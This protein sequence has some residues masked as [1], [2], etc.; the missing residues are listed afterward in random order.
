MKSMVL[1]EQQLKDKLNVIYKE[2]LLNV[3]QE[4]WDKLTGTEK[5]F[6]F[7]FVKNSNPDKS[8]L[9]SE[10]TFWNSLGDIVGIFDPTGLVDLVNG[11]SY[12]KQGDLLFG[13]LSV[14]SA[15]PY[16]GD[17][18]AKPVMGALKLGKPVTKGLDKA[19]KLSNAGKTAE[20]VKVIEDISKTS[21][22][23]KKLIDSTVK[24]GPKLKDIINKM[25]GSNKLTK[26]LGKTINEWIDLFLSAAQRS[27]VS[28][29]AL[30]NLAKKGTKLTA[31]EIKTLKDT[32]KG[33]GLFRGYK[34]TDP[35]LTYKF[36]NLTSGYLWRNPSLRTLALKTKTWL[37]FLDFLG[38]GN[39][40]G[41]NELKQS[42]GE[43]ELNSKLNEYLN[44][45]K[46]KEYIKQDFTFNEEEKT[47]KIPDLPQ[48]GSKSLDPFSMIAS[49]LLGGSLR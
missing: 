20:A 49:Q 44:T 8:Y 30:S 40:V 38:L 32:L 37:G 15:V 42:M 26:G 13:F 5:K 28:R 45:S 14:V 43:G 31:A 33:S 39:F 12:I 3:L 48:S 24:W 11:I 46:G 1:N 25:I 23:T 35:G 2:E 17:A 7:E 19:L 34:M 47:E 22:I 21:P 41:P 27:Q 10:S 16:F 29:V 36:F 9:L 6:I 4:R 18:A